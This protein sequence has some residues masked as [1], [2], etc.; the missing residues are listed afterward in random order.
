EPPKDAARRLAASLTGNTPLMADLN[1]LCD[2]IG[3]RPTGSP[4]C[5]RAIEWAAARF[6]DAGADR[7]VTEEFTI[8]HRWVPQ[9]AEA[10][11]LT[12]VPL[13]LRIAAAPFT[14]STTGGRAV[15]SRLWVAGE[16]AAQDFARL[17]ANAR[18]AI[19]L[20]R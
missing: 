19:V 3:G 18:G 20:V 11:V 17:G 7:V 12:P 9:T 14:P 15:E 4:A 16:G 1:E 2:A 6:R 10:R 8:P 5:N 13:E